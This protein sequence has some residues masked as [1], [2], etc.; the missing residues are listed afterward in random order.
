MTDIMPRELKSLIY[1]YG[2]SEGTFSPMECVFLCDVYMGS[3]PTLSSL[4][5]QCPVVKGYVELVY[6][7]DGVTGAL[8]TEKLNQEIELLMDMSRL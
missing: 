4:A 1:R 7:G 8:P 6:Q 3:K 2:L 5:Y